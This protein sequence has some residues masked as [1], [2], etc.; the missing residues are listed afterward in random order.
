MHGAAP[1]QWIV[2][3]GTDQTYLVADDF[4]WATAKLMELSEKSA[5]NR[6]VSLLEGGYDLQG[7]A[8]SAATHIYRLMR[9]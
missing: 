6:V 8:E 1:G 3:D 5:D 9:G 4:D 2:V 7:L